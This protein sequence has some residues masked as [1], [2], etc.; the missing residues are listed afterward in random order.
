VAIQREKDCG[1]TAKSRLGIP[2]L[3]AGKIITEIG[4]SY[5]S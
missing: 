1:I 5:R 2:N 3:E 4:G